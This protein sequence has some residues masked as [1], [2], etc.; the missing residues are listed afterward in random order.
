MTCT[1]GL[2]VGRHLNLLKSTLPTSPVRAVVASVADGTDP[3]TPIAHMLGINVSHGDIGGTEMAYAVP[4][5]RLGHLDRVL[6]AR[7][8]RCTD[9]TVILVVVVTA[10]HSDLEERKFHL[11][12]ISSQMT[13]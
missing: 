13:I 9:D 2:L 4:H 8:L 10:R 7:F 5:S 12:I 1:C 11:K 6:L 3:R